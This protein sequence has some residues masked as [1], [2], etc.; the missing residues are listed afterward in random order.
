MF[1]KRDNTPTAI[2]K[3]KQMASVAVI[4]SVFGD[5]DHIKE[6]QGPHEGVDFFL[7]TEPRHM[8]PSQSKWTYVYDILYRDNKEKT[9]RFSVD[10]PSATIRNMMRAKYFKTQWSHI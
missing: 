8:R 9:I 7:F 1:F 6:P 3:K 2:D 4:S 5:Y 10:S